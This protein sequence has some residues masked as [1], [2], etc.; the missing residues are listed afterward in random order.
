MQKN[1]IGVSDGVEIIFNVSEQ[2]KKIKIF[3]TRPET[4]FGAT[5][6]ALSVEHEISSLFDDDSEFTKFKHLCIKAQ[7]KRDGDEKLAFETKLNFIH[8]FI[9]KKIP[10]FFSNYVLMDYGS[11]AIFGC[12]AHDK[13]DYDFALKNNLNIIKVIQDINSSSLP[14]CEINKEDKIINSDFLDNLHPSEAKK[15]NRRNT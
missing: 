13:R 10:I 14:Y 15:D 11:G 1:W 7:K 2:D 3:T 12:P 8:P 4:I 5:F 6:I 9:K